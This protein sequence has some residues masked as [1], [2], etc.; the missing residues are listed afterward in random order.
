MPYKHLTS[1]SRA[2]LAS[3]RRAGHNQKQIAALLGKDPSTISRELKRNKTKRGYHA[4]IASQKAANR[5][6]VANQRFRKLTPGA[7]LTKYVTGRLKHYW[8]PDQIAGRLKYETGR[9]IV[10]YMTIYDYIRS[11]K[12]YKRYLRYQKPYRHH[13][14]ARKREKQRELDKK[15]WIDDRPKIVNERGRIGDWEGDTVLGKGG[16][17]PRLLTYAERKSGKAKAIKVLGG[18]GLAENVTALTEKHFKN[19][20]A[21]KKRTMTYDNGIEFSDHEVIEKRT[22]M[23]V[24]FAHPYHSWERGTNENTNGLYR[25]FFPKKHDLT[26]VSQRDIDR[27][28]RLLN[29]RPRKRHHY[30]TPDEVFHSKKSKK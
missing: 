26:N 7:N 18:L 12:A 15:R 3:L 30:Q 9:Q 29:T 10:S 4:R 27:A 11:H 1:S 19:L 13:Y 23:T 21:D 6:L 20:P 22:G 28:T 25:Q 5:R 24:Y 2:R 17:S 14:G 16:K 8:S